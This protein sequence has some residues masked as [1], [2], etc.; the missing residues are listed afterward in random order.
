MASSQTG[1]RRR[2]RKAVAST[3]ADDRSS[4]WIS[5]R[6]RT[7]GR[8]WVKRT[9]ASRTARPMARESGG[10]S[11]AS[12]L[13]S[14]ISSAARRGGARPPASSSMTGSMRSDSPANPNP[15]SASALRCASTD[16]P[17]SAASRM[18]ACHRMVLPIPGSPAS[19]NAAGPS[20]T[21]PSHAL[22]AASSSSRPMRAASDTSLRLSHTR[23][24]WFQRRPARVHLGGAR[25][26]STTRAALRPFSAMTDPPGCVA[27][28]HRYT[29]SMPVR[30]AQRR[31]HI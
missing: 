9:S 14:A 26:S 6:A 13:S 21:A 17:A 27:A 16:M 7:T 2:R 31:S 3:S 10:T 1:S 30:G 20:A 19:T 12:A 25:S 11:P 5:S 22:I 4:H 18:P 8:D 28:P 23:W 29:P 24:L 15:A